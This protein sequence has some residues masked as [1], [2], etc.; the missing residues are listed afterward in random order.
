MK[1]AHLLSSS[2]APGSLFQLCPVPVFAGLH[3]AR[4]QQQQ[5]QRH[6]DINSKQLQ[7]KNKIS[8]APHTAA[9]PTFPQFQRGVQGGKRLKLAAIQY[10][11]FGPKMTCFESRNIFWEC[12]PDS[13]APC[14]AVRRWPG[15]C[16]QTRGKNVAGNTNQ[17]CRQAIFASLRQKTA[18][19]WY[20][21]KIFCLQNIISAILK[22]YCQVLKDQ[23]QTSLN[24]F[25]QK[26]FQRFNSTFK[27][28]SNKLNI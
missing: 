19:G 20:F 17:S 7:N 27:N 8:S 25:S 11:W 9:Q 12:R 18:F 10:L 1:T 14:C 22:L 2:A 5:Q 13:G 15:R 24:M 26:Q 3:H 28:L 6:N 21:C 4:Q 23:Q 16:S